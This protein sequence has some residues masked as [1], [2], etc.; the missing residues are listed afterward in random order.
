V[1]KAFLQ[2][3]TWDSSGKVASEGRRFAVQFNPETLKLTFSNQLAGDNNR[4]G[5]AIQFASRGTTKLSFEMWFDVS[6]PQPDEADRKDDVRRL[7]QEVVAF[8][9][10]TQSGS[11]QGARFTPPGCRFQWGTFLFEGVME[12]INEN[13]EFFS[14]EGKPLR[15]SVSV[16]LT[17]QDVEV[18]FAELSAA[19]P[20]GTQPQQQA[21]EGDSVQAMSA[22]EGHPEGWQQ[23]A[24]TE[25][26]EDPLRVPAGTAL[27]S[28]NNRHC[29]A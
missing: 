2:E 8:M 10:T 23:R 18:R 4:G 17:K 26:I 16:S 3:I 24:R 12:S 25:G 5:S 19:P 13:L 11:G 9:K 21:R 29:P 27:P 14:P 7:T 1:T 20:A 15:A 28:M 22:R 6:A